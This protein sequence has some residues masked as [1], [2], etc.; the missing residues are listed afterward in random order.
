MIHTSA[1]SPIRISELAVPGVTGI[2]GVTFCPGK[3]DGEKWDRDLDADLDAIRA[4]GARAVIT[5][6]EEHEFTMLRV[7]SLGAGVAA[8]DMRWHHLPIRD[9]NAP[10]VRFEKGWSAAWPQIRKHL[11]DGERVV[12]H[13]RGGLGRA[14]TVAARALIEFGMDPEDAIRAVRDARPGAI[15]TSEQLTYLRCLQRRR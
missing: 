11:M 7:Q 12:V 15:E 4:W 3:R 5:L 14:G 13:C 1:S 8:R 2:I 10:D 9:L 6:I